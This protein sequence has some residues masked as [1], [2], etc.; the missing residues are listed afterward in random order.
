MSCSQ[1]EYQSIVVNDNQQLNLNGLQAQAGSPEIQVNSSSN[2]Y[3]EQGE[4][5]RQEI[6][7]RAGQLQQVVI[8]SMDILKNSSDLI[9]RRLLEQLNIRLDQAK[10]KADKIINEVSY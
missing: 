10:S 7:R 6:V 8:S 2:A 9:V 1:N 4:Q 3:R 5:L